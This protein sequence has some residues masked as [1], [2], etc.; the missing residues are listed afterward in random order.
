M[1]PQFWKMKQP[2]RARGAR[3]GGNTGSGKPPVHGGLGGEGT[4]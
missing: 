1:S 2:C 4:G 3:G